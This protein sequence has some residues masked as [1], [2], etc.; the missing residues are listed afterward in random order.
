MARVTIVVPVWN[1]VALTAAC[2]ESL[3]AGTPPELYEVVVVDNAS[4][5]ATPELC[6][7]LE[8][9]VTV[10]RNECN[11]GFGPACNQGAAA[12][13]S[14]T[15]FL[16]FLNNDTLLRPGW[17]EPLIAV[18]DEDPRCGAVQPKLIYPDGRL[19]DAGGL[20]FAGGDAWVYGK[21]HPVP[22]APQF[23]CR[24]A[25]DYASGAC[26]LVR[27]AA[28]AAVGG[29]D[30]RYAPAYYEDTDLSFALRS[31]GWRVLY[32][33]ASVV[34]HLEGGTAGT[35]TSAGMKRYQVVNREKFAT[36][37][38]GELAGRPALDP[39]VVEAWAH[40]PQGGM[41]PG[42][43]PAMAVPSARAR[44][45]LVF[46]PFLPAYDRSSGQR[47]L[48]EVLRILRA[49]GH[50][51]T[52]YAA[53]AADRDRYGPVLSRLGIAAWGP[54]P[55]RRP[56]G[57]VAAAHYDAVFNPGLAPLAAQRA[58]DTVLLSSWS[59]AEALLPEVRRLLPAATAIVDSVDVHF[60]REERGARV[61]GDAAA[62][63]AARR[64]RAR[65]MAVYRAAD[66]VWAVTPDD[67]EAI[68]RE[69]GVGHIAVVPNIHE[70]C[71]PGPPFGEREGLVFVANFSHPPNYDALVW[72]C[73]EVGPALE[74][75]LGGLCLTVVGYD[76]CGDGAALAR[77]GVRVVGWVPDLR[78]WLHA[79][80]VFVA[81]LRFGAGMKGKVGEALA[82]GTPVVATSVA[83]EGMGITPGVHAL[84][85]DDPGAFADAICA[86][87]TDEARW[88]GL[89]EAGRRLVAER[90]SPTAVAPVV[91]E[92]VGTRLT[93]AAA[94]AR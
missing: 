37:W 10:I 2:L 75:R 42:E 23:S 67:A 26:L 58:Y 11:L 84:V 55:G 18:M 77:P 17:L 91:L 80:R 87:Y 7:A 22:D 61:L 20:V 15:D 52:Y 24:R 57:A 53:N 6:E 76:P 72:W 54:E 4:T 73:E 29:F 83:A 35:D 65:E 66:S 64:T 14:E 39:A 36:K 62:M 79:A 45:I 3:A 88:G 34:T 21:G 82:A 68:R 25:P 63:A 40:R 74:E 93:P 13:R 41:G 92:A 59:V 81:P 38:A 48:L 1:Q 90:Y 50:H 9:D 43:D 27:K 8:G 70:V 51:V 78:P 30:P 69:G 71:D 33:P 16:L 46:D 12:A 85:A 31:A 60:V 32:E 19:C 86:L 56:V 94:R 49:G 44:T 89:A 28:F 47:R 5:D